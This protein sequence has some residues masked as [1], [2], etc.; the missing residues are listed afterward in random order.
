MCGMV[1]DESAGRSSIG[2]HSTA[3]DKVEPSSPVPAH[4]PRPP[5]HPPPNLFACSLCLPAALAAVLRAQGPWPQWPDS[6]DVLELLSRELQVQHAP[7]ARVGQVE[8]PPS[9]PTRPVDGQRAAAL[10]CMWRGAASG[11]PHA[12]VGPMHRNRL[13]VIVSCASVRDGIHIQRAIFIDPPLRGVG[14]QDRPPL[15][16][17]RFLL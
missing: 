5:R 7:E 16:P 10:K 6:S 13:C 11:V 4:A 15:S 12:E 9:C 17:P 3:L 8:Q 14:A 1:A 2:A